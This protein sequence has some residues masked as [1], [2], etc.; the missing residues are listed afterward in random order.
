MIIHEL[1]QV[2]IRKAVN[3]E[4]A[5]LVFDS[6]DVNIRYEASKSTYVT[7]PRQSKTPP[8]A[9]FMYPQICI[10]IGEP[11]SASSTG[12]IRHLCAEW[13]IGFDAIH[14][15]FEW[16]HPDTTYETFGIRIYFSEWTTACQHSNRITKVGFNFW[17]R[18]FLTGFVEK[19]IYL[20]FLSINILHYSKV[21][22]GAMASQITQL[23]IQAQIKETIKAPRHWPLSGEFTGD[24][25]I[26]RTNGQ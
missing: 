11:L 1:L 7:E 9:C 4:S 26:P 21:T 6:T 2:T 8:C 12:N 19:K 14:K 13:E 23:F 20:N 18:L 10:K 25:W 22:M 15:S 16:R 5:F 17:Y 24:R 3:R